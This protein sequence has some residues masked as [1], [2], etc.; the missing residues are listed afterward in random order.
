MINQSTK[1][2]IELIAELRRLYASVRPP[3][4]HSMAQL[5]DL[6]LT[7]PQ[8]KVMFLLLDAPPARMSALA[9]DLGITLSACTYLVDRLVTAGY[10][11]RSED[12]ADRR[13]VRCSLTASGKDV[14]DKLR[15]QSPVASDEFIAHLSDD[16]LRV[17]VKSME[18]YYRVMS[19]MDS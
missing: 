19:E 15:Q 2:R 3:R 12:P 4:N 1:E 14:L 6:E 10:V 11:E 16:D 5:M 13:V 8:L 7:F 18:I 9:Q 17:L